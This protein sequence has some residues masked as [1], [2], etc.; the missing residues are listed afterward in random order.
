MN[1]SILVLLLI[2]KLNCF[3]SERF[4]IYYET[5][6]K[7]SKVDNFLIYKGTIITTSQTDKYDFQS[8]IVCGINSSSLKYETRGT[9]S[10]VF[11]IPPKSTLKIQIV[12]FCMNKGFSPPSTINGNHV[13]SLVIKDKFVDDFCKSQS[14]IHELYQNHH[15]D[16]VVINTDYSYPEDDSEPDILCYKLIL[17]VLKEALDKALGIKKIFNLTINGTKFEN[18]GNYKNP[19]DKICR[20]KKGDIISI[21]TDKNINQ[22]I[23]ISVDA[24][25]IL[26]N[27][28]KIHL[29][30]I[31]KPTN[32][33]VKLFKERL[34]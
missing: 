2:I 11:T 32:E 6:N 26:L 29:E 27:D 8:L 18:D 3:A 10:W 25:S 5:F 9:N 17:G 1:K 12:C 15:D 34:K 20:L 7:S 14:S 31:G 21:S 23:I 33:F 24:S 13:S 30:G 28:K 22:E 19:L 16:L 4:I